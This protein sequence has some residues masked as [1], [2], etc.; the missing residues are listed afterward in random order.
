[1]LVMVVAARVESWRAK[2]RRAAPGEDVVS[3]HDEDALTTVTAQD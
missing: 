2:R 1:V 3:G